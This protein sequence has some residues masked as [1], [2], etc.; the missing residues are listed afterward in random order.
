MLTETGFLVTAFNHF[1]Y[2]WGYYVFSSWLPTYLKS[3]NY[4]L[5]STG[6]ISF[7]PYILMPFV[8]IPS[9]IL[10]DKLISSGRIPTVYVR[11][12]FQM[13]GTLIP[14]FF[15][16]LLS[17][18]RPPA[19][20]AVVMMVCALACAPFSTAGYNSNYLDLTTK[21]TGIL[22]SFS[23]TTATIP[24]IIGVSLT[25]YILDSS[26]QNWSIVFLLAASIYIAAAVLF[27][28]FAK[29][30]TV[31]FDDENPTRSPIG[32]IIQ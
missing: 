18:M 31:D 23:N 32:S 14:T 25:G 5:S 15:L 13:A 19:T 20:V 16:I 1:A 2:N 6:I 30:E 26:H 24:G 4:D 28:F 29:G 12:I 8:G 7:L 22:Y 21:Y 10:A 9:G 11:K 27:L 3:L 17:V